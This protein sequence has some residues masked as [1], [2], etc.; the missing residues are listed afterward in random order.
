MSHGA[1]RA[2][3]KR[4][5]DGQFARSSVIVLSCRFVQQAL[6]INCR[7]AGA[8][9]RLLPDCFHTKR[10][11][12]HAGLLFRS[13]ALHS[14]PSCESSV[15]MRPAPQPRPRR[16]NAY[17]QFDRVS[18]R[19]ISACHSCAACLAD[20]PGALALR[21][22]ARNVAAIAKRHSPATVA[23]HC[24]L[25]AVIGD[26][27]LDRFHFRLIGKRSR[28]YPRRHHDRR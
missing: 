27:D 16:R 9:N 26:A 3:R 15:L 24:R 18:F 7:Q 14:A 4:P 21:R 19:D 22:P 20:G 1:W 25:V 11:L 10:T 12:R 2:T 17:A 23:S 8:Q 28:S 6:T 13:A 5:P